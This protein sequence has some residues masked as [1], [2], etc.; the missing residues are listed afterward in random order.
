M[1]SRTY[2]KKHTVITEK[3]DH[4]NLRFFFMITEKNDHENSSIFKR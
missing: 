4:K 3:N 2:R 1:K